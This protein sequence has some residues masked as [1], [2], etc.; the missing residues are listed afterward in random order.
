MFWSHIFSQICTQDVHSFEILSATFNNKKAFS[1][2]HSYHFH[3]SI[4]YLAFLLG[5]TCMAQ[6]S[7]LRNFVQKFQGCIFCMI[8]TI[9]TNLALLSIIELRRTNTR[10]K[11]VIKV[12]IKAE[13][14]DFGFFAVLLC[15]HDRFM[16]IYTGFEHS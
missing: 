8:M 6:W 3:S 4:F 7:F 16:L 14:V 9:C 10:P 11:K 12:N 1:G 15:F 5:Y 2:S 13:Q